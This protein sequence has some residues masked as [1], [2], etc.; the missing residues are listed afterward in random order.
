LVPVPIQ[1]PRGS[2]SWPSSRP[3]P[4]QATAHSSW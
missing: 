4:A 3:D 1:P 2:T